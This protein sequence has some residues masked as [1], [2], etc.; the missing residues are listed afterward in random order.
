VI[1]DFG[2]CNDNSFLLKIM[3]CV[4]FPL[5]LNPNL[6]DFVIIEI[7]MTIIRRMNMRLSDD[8]LISKVNRMND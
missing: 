3:V 6:V 2:G 4:H 8:I 7:T 1:L 5:N